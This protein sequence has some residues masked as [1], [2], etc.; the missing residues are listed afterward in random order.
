MSLSISVLRSA[1]EVNE[2]MTMKWPWHRA[3]TEYI[4]DESKKRELVSMSLGESFNSPISPVPKLRCL[5]FVVR[6]LDKDEFSRS[7]QL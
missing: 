1:G 4:R 3:G 2:T 6:G 5:I 7:F